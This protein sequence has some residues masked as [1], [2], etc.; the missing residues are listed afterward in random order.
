MVKKL[1]NGKNKK[2]LIIVSLVI[3][4][5]LIYVF[6]DQL[7]SLLGME[8]FNTT[9]QSPLSNFEKYNFQG[10]ELD[11]FNKLNGDENPSTTPSSPQPIFY[12][13]DTDEKL[14]EL[15]DNQTKKTLKQN[16]VITNTL[17]MENQI[18]KP[19][20]KDKDNAFNGT[21]YMLDGIEISNMKIEVNNESY[22][23]FAGLVGFLGTNGKIINV[24]LGNKNTITATSTGV[25]ALSGGICGWN[26]GS[27]TDCS[28]GD[29]NIITATSTSE[30][31]EA[32]SGG[33]C[34]YNEGSIDGEIIGDNNIIVADI[35]TNAYFTYDGVDNSV[36]TR[37]PR[38]NQKGTHSDLSSQLKELN[39]KD[40]IKNV[41]SRVLTDKQMDTILNVLFGVPL[42]PSTTS[43]T[44]VPPPTL[45]DIT[46]PVYFNEKDSDPSK[47]IVNKCN[48]A[49]LFIFDTQDENP[50]TTTTNTKQLELSTDTCYYTLNLR[51][52][53]CNEPIRNRIRDQ[54]ISGIKIN[55]VEC[56]LRNETPET[57]YGT[58][59]NPIENNKIIQIT[60]NLTITKNSNEILE[61]L[62]DIKN[63]INN[64][65]NQRIT[66]TNPPLKRITTTNPPLKR[67][68]TNPPLK[69]ITTNP[70]LKTHIH[71]HEIEIS[72]TCNNFKKRK[73]TIKDSVEKNLNDKFEHDITIRILQCEDIESFNTNNNNN[74]KA[75]IPIE[76]NHEGI[77]SNE[78]NE[79][80]SRTKA[81]VNDLIKTLN[82]NSSPGSSISEE[83]NP[84]QYTMVVVGVVLVGCLTVG[85]IKRKEIK[86]M[87]K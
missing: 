65:N 85:Y 69:R 45:N 87:F 34:G 53:E 33:I 56:K 24:K 27:I 17:N 73:S 83:T 23:A 28:I 37:S 40:Y 59:P 86:K 54:A 78:I 21:L 62:Q 49:R 38:R 55:T 9:T 1:F 15:M 64:P 52:Q 48:H 16:Y 32:L 26:E 7:K 58:T 61:F 66:T 79:I 57:T 30:D 50:S 22:F 80:E 77:K 5:L 72:G 13:I 25:V 82:L 20:G 67:I 42:P 39:L 31:S 76:I 47:L 2:L 46:I 10:E 44:T 70:P 68:T 71:T 81:F 12:K 74:N 29:N 51:N 3:F 8:N 14:K 35:E 60:F 19:I 41:Y 36:T 18:C 75:K 4:I 43:L 63:S 11:K 84:V 6:K